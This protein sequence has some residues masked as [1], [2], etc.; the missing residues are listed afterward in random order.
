MSVTSSRT[1]ATE[2]NSC[3]TL[4]ICTD[5]IAEPC[6]EDRSTRRN[7]FP[8]VRPNPRSNGSAITV[9]IRSGSAPGLISNCVGFIS[10][11]QFLWIIR[12]S[13]LVHWD[14]SGLANARG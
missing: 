3:R 11:C 4:S 6:N 13:I 10:S 2:E 9:A 12:A 14:D 5:V 8:K 1:P 7:A